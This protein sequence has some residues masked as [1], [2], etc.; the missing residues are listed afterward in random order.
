MT[1]A[2][3]R[4]L[5]IY[6]CLGLLTLP[7]YFLDHAV[8]TPSG[9]NWIALDF[10]GLLFWSY[11][12]WAAIYFALSLIALLFCRSDARLPFHLGLM[13]LSL[14][15]LVGGCG[16][17]AKVHDLVERHQYAVLMERRKALFNV[18]EL[19]DWRYYPDQIS[20]T[21][22]RVTV[23]I[24]DSGRFAGNVTGEQTDS[25]DT[26]TTV[27]QSANEPGDQKQVSNGE[28]FNY[29]FPLQNLNRGHA[30][31]VSIALYLFKASSGPATGDITKVFM[32]SP[33]QDDDGQYF[34]GL[35]PPPSLPDKQRK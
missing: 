10:R 13:A 28:T 32:N 24:H 31:K 34:Y 3:R 2:W 25:S 8:F 9:S 18:I 16:V 33:H 17:Y 21:E 30:D 1:S 22:I 15:L 4:Q 7:I 29:V 14:I 35:L 20:P 11:L 27:F 26:S 6:S 19:K 23:T 5:I 12:I